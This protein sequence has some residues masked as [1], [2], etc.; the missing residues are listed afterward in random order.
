MT[1]NADDDGAVST[2]YGRVPRELVR[3]RPGLEMVFSEDDRHQAS[4]GSKPT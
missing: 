2:T 3:R 1:C 4:L